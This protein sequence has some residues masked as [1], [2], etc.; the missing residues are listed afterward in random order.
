MVKNQLQ[1]ERQYLLRCL[2]DYLQQLQN[3]ASSGN[4]T[5][6]PKYEVSQIVQEITAVRQLETK[7]TDMEG[8]AE[9]LLNDLQGYDQ[10][11]QKISEFL[12][13]IKQQHGDLFDSWTVEITSQ[14]ESNKLR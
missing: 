11:I 9:K 2:N 5:N 8:I 4:V 12:K 13:E 1:S 10:F 7:G 14:I 6:I 3:E